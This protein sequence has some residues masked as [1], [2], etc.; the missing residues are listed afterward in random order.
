MFNNPF[1]CWPA[2]AVARRCRSAPCVNGILWGLPD[3]AMRS[4]LP[5]FLAGKK[6]VFPSNSGTRGPWSR[7]GS[8]F[9][10]RNHR[11]QDWWSL[12]SEYPWW[13]PG[14]R[15]GKGNRGWD[16]DERRLQR[17]T[18]RQNFQ[19]QSGMIMI[20]DGNCQTEPWSVR[21]KGGFGVVKIVCFATGVVL[22]VD[23][24]IPSESL[25]QHVN[26]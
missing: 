12:S 11:A 9:V 19:D 16:W 26:M 25:N 8:F 21:E 24:W 22:V 2:G 6:G 14:C 7:L 3:L 13:H 1:S 5:Q 15:G 10:A 4:I 17:V 18:W 20:Y 23:R